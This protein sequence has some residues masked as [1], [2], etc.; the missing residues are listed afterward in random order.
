MVQPEEAF[1]FMQ[2]AFPLGGEVDIAIL[3]PHFGGADAL[4]CTS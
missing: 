2:Q 3:G 1:V 4:K